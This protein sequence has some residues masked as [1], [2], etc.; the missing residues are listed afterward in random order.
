MVRHRRCGR[1]FQV[2]EKH[3]MKEGHFDSCHHFVPEDVLML[4]YWEVSSVQGPRNFCHRLPRFESCI[5]PLLAVYLG[6][7]DFQSLYQSFP[8]LKLYLCKELLWGLINV[9][10]FEVFRTGQI[11]SAQST[12]AITTTINIILFFLLDLCLLY[13][14][15]TSGSF[16]LFCLDLSVT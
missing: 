2:A 12:V 13:Y 4:Q 8:I 15:S 16:S 3:G 14:L 6:T 1:A 9:S 7:I 5:C 11:V 10:P